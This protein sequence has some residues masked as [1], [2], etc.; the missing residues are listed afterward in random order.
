[1]SLFYIR[2]RTHYRY[3][4]Q[5]IDSAN[6]IKLYP[7]QDQHQRVT[8]H[9]LFVSTQPP[10]QTVRDYFGN[11]TGFFTV[12]QPH[13]ELIIDSRVTVEMTEHPVIHKKEEAM[14][15]WQQLNAPENHLLFHDFLKAEEAQ[16]Q[17]EIESAVHDILSKVQHP[18]D[19]ILDL[20]D[21][22]YHHFTYKKG[23]TTI[24]TSVD[25]LWNLRAGVCQDFAHLL[26]YM[27]RLLGIPGRYISGYICP[28]SSEWRG[29]GA[30]H[31]WVEAWLPDTGWIGVDPT[32]KCLAGG[33]HVRLASGRHFSDCTPV[34]GTYKGATEHK[35]EV[36]VQFGEHA[37]TDE[38]LSEQKPTF[39]S[40]K[41]QAETLPRN[42]YMAYLQLQQQQ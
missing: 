19:T 31:A 18:L 40:G 22:I 35:L 12:I 24:E 25:E 41:E 39:T 11:L 8:D 13:T 23:V 32:N 7:V 9:H 42:S 14:G 4:G 16:Y 15:I 20:S 27:L 28:G 34:K 37:F 5:V 2:H 30:T 3:S 1:M 29:E 36:T 21:Y 10:I 6:Q 33:R 26:L 38:E 17:S